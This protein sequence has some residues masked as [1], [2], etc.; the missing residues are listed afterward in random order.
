MDGIGRYNGSRT[1][2][3]LF[4]AFEAYYHHIFYCLSI[5]E[6][7]AGLHLKSLVQLLLSII[8]IFVGI[9]FT[10]E[11]QETTTK[12]LPQKMQTCYNQIHVWTKKCKHF[13]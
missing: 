9:Q 2:I 1:T 13:H 8:S 6:V 7:S 12:K 3:L 11:L 10:N 4:T 5:C